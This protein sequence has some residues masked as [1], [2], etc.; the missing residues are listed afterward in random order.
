MQKI[1]MVDIGSNTV[2]L[3]VYKK[4]KK[5]Q[6]HVD[7]NVKES[8]R[9][10]NYLIDDKITDEGINIL[11]RVLTNYQKTIEQKRL[12]YVKYFATQTIRMAKNKKEVIKRVYDE[13][14]IIIDILSEEEEALLGFEGMNHF[15]KHEKNGV[16]MDMGGGSTELVYYV[17]NKPVEYVSLDFG[18]IVLRQMIEDAI[19]TK[20]EV[21]KIQHFVK[22]K[23]LQVEWAR[24]LHTPLVVVGGS[25]RNLVR[26]DK[27][28]SS[29]IDET[30]GY[31]LSFRGLQRTRKILQLLTVDEI[32]KIN[33]F[34]PSR[35]DIIVASFVAFETIYQ[36][37]NARYYVCS[38]TGLREGI[39][40]QMLGE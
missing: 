29:R 17:D 6:Y 32:R 36:F 11:I 18:S 37:V 21:K 31:T 34:T 38:K 33:G 20:E 1:A 28:L 14:D 8:V 9:L 40:L 25:S 23:L 19:P 4:G 39:L 30:H 24:G 35:A 13:L 26:I 2:R 10:R 7:L 15:L 16:Y 27:F 3:C 5:D 22:D 12:K